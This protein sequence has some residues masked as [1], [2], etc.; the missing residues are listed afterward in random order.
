[1]PKSRGG[2]INTAFI[3]RLNATFRQSLAPLARRTRY[4]ARQPDTLQAG[5][6]LVGTVYNLCTYH[7]S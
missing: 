1:M 7:Q 4:P 2:V 3:E 5:M 6:F